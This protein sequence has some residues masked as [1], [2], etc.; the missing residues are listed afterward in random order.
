MQI[1]ARL[2]A[3]FALL[4]FTVSIIAGFLAGNSAMVILT[5]ALVAMVL[6][7]FIGQ[8][9]GWGCKLVLREHLQAIKRDIDLIHANYLTA[10]DAAANGSAAEPAEAEAVPVDASPTSPGTQ[11]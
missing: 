1:T 7:L 6:A 4:A 11:T 3:Q 2:G 10:R 8:L 9:V 5:R